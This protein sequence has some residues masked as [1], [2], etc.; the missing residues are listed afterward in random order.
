[1]LLQPLFTK[2][3][4]ATRFYALFMFSFPQKHLTKLKLLPFQLNKIYENIKSHL[5]IECTNIFSKG[6]LSMTTKLNGKKSYKKSPAINTTGIKSI[7]DNFMLIIKYS[8]NCISKRQQRINIKFSSY[9][10][11]GKMKMENMNKNILNNVK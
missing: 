1:M 3:S 4:L 5:F 7:P 10:K 9:E 6:C 11:Q 2:N 8:T